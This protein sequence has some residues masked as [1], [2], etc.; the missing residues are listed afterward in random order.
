[1]WGRA[2]ESHKPP[3][4]ILEALQRGWATRKPEWGNEHFWVWQGK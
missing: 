2:Q 3:T 4:N 1:M